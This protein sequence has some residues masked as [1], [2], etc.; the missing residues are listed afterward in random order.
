MARPLSVTD[1]EI[2]DVANRVIAMRGPEHFSV[3][4]VAREVGLSRAAITLRFHSAEDLKRLLMQR[5][6]EQ[7][8]RLLASLEIKRGAEGLL[9]IAELIGAKA[10]SRN[11]VANF[12]LRMSRNIH[13][14][15]L[16]ELEERR[17][18]SLR[19]VIGQAMPR[20]AIEHSAA[21]DAFLAHLSGSLLQ[22]QASEEPDGRRFLRDRTFD[23]L[24][25][26]GVPLNE[27]LE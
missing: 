17:G 26:A 13:D 10:G 6:A 24:R 18:E 11:G 5:R 21:V 27:G 15:V 19:S 3:S 23:W 9:A 14:P 25:L 1:E 22:W 4:E 20:T 16:L 12:M 8:D 7:F 2:L